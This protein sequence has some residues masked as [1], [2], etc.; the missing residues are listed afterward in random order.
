MSLESN[1]EI[2]DVSGSTNCLPENADE[3]MNES[4]LNGTNIHVHV[5]LELNLEIKDFSGSTNLIRVINSITEW[6]TALKKSCDV[7]ITF[8][9]CLCTRTCRFTCETKKLVTDTI[10]RPPKSSFIGSYIDIALYM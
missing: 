8:I 7:T 3:F 1:S 9:P 10:T 5:G 4:I 6:H 2:K